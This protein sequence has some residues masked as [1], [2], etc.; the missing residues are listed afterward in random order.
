[1]GLFIYAV[2]WLAAMAGGR[3]LAKYLMPLVFLCRTGVPTMVA[4]L[5]L[6]RIIDRQGAELGFHI[7]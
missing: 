4:L 3:C 7:P 6:H 5:L 2:T 1:M